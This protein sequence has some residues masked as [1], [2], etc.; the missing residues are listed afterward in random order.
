MVGSVT[1]AAHAEGVADRLPAAAV[2][3][4]VIAKAIAKA[5]EKAI[6]K[7]FRKRPLQELL[8]GCEGSH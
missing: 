2:I 3:A 1:V 6:A 5:I 4:K 7:S 8:A